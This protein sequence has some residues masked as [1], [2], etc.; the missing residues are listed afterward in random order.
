MNKELAEYYRIAVD[1]ETVDEGRAGGWGVQTIYMSMGKRHDYCDSLQAVNAPVLIVHGAD[2]PYQPEDASRSYA[3]AFPNAEYRTV[4]GA[5][6]F[7]FYN[8]PDAF[9]E[10]VAEFLGELE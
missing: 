9:A 5:G 8:R 4:E 10:I 1:G 7:P 3:D 2:A 6:H